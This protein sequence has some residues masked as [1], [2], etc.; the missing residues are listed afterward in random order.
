MSAEDRR[1]YELQ[2]RLQEEREAELRKM[3]ILR[4]VLTP[5]ARQRLANLKMV[6]PDFV[7]QL[8]LQLINLAT[9]GQIEVPIDDK[10]LK[11]ILMKFQSNRRR[12]RIKRV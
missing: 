7:N 2:R 8:E 11:A 3:A 12:M 4:K 5:E 10:Q 1:M 9:S 6:R